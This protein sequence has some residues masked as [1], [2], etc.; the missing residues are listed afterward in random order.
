MR[1]LSVCHFH[2]LNSSHCRSLRYLL[3]VCSLEQLPIQS[4]YILFSPDDHF[5]E[6]QIASDLHICHKAFSQRC[7]DIMNT[8]IEYHPSKT[9]NYPLF[10]PES[11]TEGAMRQYL[12]LKCRHEIDNERRRMMREL[13][14]MLWGGEVITR[15]FNKLKK[16]ISSD[17]D[18]FQLC[19]LVVQSWVVHLQFCGDIDF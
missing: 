18:S 10:F 15:M 19:E 11:T 4:L 9:Q 12:S 1:S 5:N 7:S 17:E 8:N 16:E 14:K 2:H 13:N 6:Y 3:V